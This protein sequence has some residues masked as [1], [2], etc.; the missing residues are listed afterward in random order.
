[1]KN[2]KSILIVSLFLLSSNL[3][4]A[5]TN[6]ENPL[7]DY[8]DKSSFDQSSNENNGTDLLKTLN[9]GSSD[10]RYIIYVPAR[11]SESD[12][13]LKAQKDLRDEISK[14]KDQ[15]AQ[16]LFEIQSRSG[17]NSSYNQC[18][19]PVAT[20]CT[21]EDQAA[22]MYVINSRSGLSGSPNDNSLTCRNEARSYQIRLTDYNLCIQNAST[23]TQIDNRARSYEIERLAAQKTY[24][25]NL[26][27]QQQEKLD[28]IEKIM[29]RNTLCQSQ[30]GIYSKYNE[31]TNDCDCQNATVRSLSS[32]F[33]CVV[34]TIST[35]PSTVR[36][37]NPVQ[38]QSVEQKPKEKLGYWDSIIESNKTKT[39]ESET[40][41]VDDEKPVTKFGLYEQYQIHKIVDIYDKVQKLKSEGNTK[42]IESIV[43]GLS[44]SEHHDYL[45]VMKY[46][47]I[48]DL[49]HNNKI[50]EAG[51]II[52]SFTE[53]EYLQYREIKLI[54]TSEKNTQV[55]ATSSTSTTPVP[56]TTLPTP[57]ESVVRK[58]FRLLSNL[59]K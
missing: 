46:K 30:H 20:G 12:K 22:Q 28:H 19:Y 17:G 11:P 5:S 15:A 33:Q 25:D 4:W 32:P 56:T 2:I 39:I 29:Q 10:Q 24:Y 52:D 41:S 21:S 9:K 53:Y 59:W 7:K 36:E 48:V 31:G 16:R 6:S 1:M 14:Q 55:V 45:I 34:P 57:Q 37:Q 35:E 47:Q 40:T 54:R 44:E 49:L 18:A 51:Y 50:T 43:G 13:L 8:F 3:V 27:A 42:E 38:I 58:F 26:L 23:Q